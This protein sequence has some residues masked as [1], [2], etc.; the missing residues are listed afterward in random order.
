[1]VRLLAVLLALMAGCGPRP[2]AAPAPRG[3][4]PSRPAADDGPALVV[5]VIDIG[6]GQAVLIEAPCGAALI[7]TG[8]ELSDGWDG[9]DALIRYLDAFFD[10]RRDLQR[11][12]SLLAITHPHIDHTR[13]IEAVLARYTV[14]GVIDNGMDEDDI[15]G[16]PQM[17]LHAWIRERAGEVRYRPIH[18][19]DIGP[20]GLTDDTIDPIQGCP[21]APVDPRIRVLW[22]ALVG[23]AEQFSK[24][25][26]DHSVAVRIDHGEASLLVP[27]DLEEPGSARLD[28]HYRAHP[29]TLDVDVWVVGHHGSRNATHRRLLE[30]MTPE[31]AVISAG[32]YQRDAPWTARA[33]GHPNKQA[34][35]KLCDP[36][37]GVRGSRPAIRPWVGIKGSWAGRPSVFEPMRIDRAVYCTCWDGTVR[38]KM[39]PS[40]RVEAAVG[41]AGG[42]SGPAT[43]RESDR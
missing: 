25:A 35:D 14:R 8:G 41:D 1:M 39:Y 20:E 32:P 17:A 29:E 30:R 33:F 15:G 43:V 6:Q 37:F 11:T 26:N 22:G 16:R 40:G 27:G 28:Q 42:A 4:A 38:V 9:V 36:A 21:G 10:R 23:G 5:H 19:D 13:G 18:A 24:N 31:I 3:R 12:L 2:P 7:D 34:L